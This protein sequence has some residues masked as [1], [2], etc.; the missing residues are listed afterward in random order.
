MGKVIYIF[1]L[2]I[3][4][5]GFVGAQPPFQESDTTEGY[6]IKVPET[7]S[8]IPKNMSY[9]IHT[10]IVNQS[11]GFPITT[12][13]SCELHLY[14]STGNHILKQMMEFDP[15]YDFEIMIDGGNFTDNGDY[16]YIIN[17]N[18]SRIGGFISDG[19]KVTPSGIEVTEEMTK[20]FL[21]S[22]M[23]LGFVSI[24]FLIFG[25]FTKSPGFKIFFVGLAILFMVA[26]VGFSVAVWQQLFGTLGNLISTYGMVFVL[27]TILIIGGGFG[28][29]VYLVYMGIISFYK[30]LRGQNDDEDDD[31]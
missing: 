26:T 27:L 3:F 8:V 28:L 1:L 22:F 18:D 7:I 31:D 23:I 20:F 25:I 14:N 6:D 17:C 13:A 24:F 10:H 9:T 5:I 29:F 16:S 2:A 11:T 15:P 19:F 4:L 21:G 12:T 30:A